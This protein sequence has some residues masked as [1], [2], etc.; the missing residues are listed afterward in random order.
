MTHAVHEHYYRSS[1]E[2]TDPVALA[3]KKRRPTLDRMAVTDFPLKNGGYKWGNIYWL[4]DGKHNG[5]HDGSKKDLPI[6]R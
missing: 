4:K 6:G 3:S 1:T 5:W 2:D